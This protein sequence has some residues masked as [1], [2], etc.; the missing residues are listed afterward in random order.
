[1]G[2]LQMSVFKRSFAQLPYFMQ[3]FYFWWKHGLFLS[4]PIKAARNCLLCFHF[5]YLYYGLFKTNPYLI[6]QY[7]FDWSIF[8]YRMRMLLRK[9]AV[10]FSFFPSSGNVWTRNPLL[11]PQMHL[12]LVSIDFSSILFRYRSLYFLSIFFSVP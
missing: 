7:F 2:L 8:L 9:I 6:D 12:L 5:M 3:K 10:L 11:L 4:T 1:M